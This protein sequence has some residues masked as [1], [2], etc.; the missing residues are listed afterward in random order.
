MYGLK[1]VPFTPHNTGRC[2]CTERVLQAGSWKESAGLRHEAAKKLKEF[3]GGF[4]SA[5]GAL[6]LLD[7]DGTLAPFRVDRFKA[8]PWVGVR[9]LLN[10]IQ[11][12]TK[13]RIAV[14][15]GRPAGEIAPLLELETPPEV[16]GL[17]GVER[18]YPDG[19]REIET[20]APE[21][22]A[23][24]DELKAQLRRNAFGGLLEEKPNAAVMHWRGVAAA[25]AREIERRTRKL[26]EPAAQMQG[27]GLL[28]FEAGVEL[29]AGRDK[30]GAVK[31]ILA[32]TDVE[33]ARKIPAA[34]LG[35]DL[36]DE[37]AFAA[38]KERGLS[39]L[40]R[41]EWRETEAD[42]WLRPPGELKGF[43]REWIAAAAGK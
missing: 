8:R 9:E 28:R 17:H 40:V 5:A 6:L 38:L 35:D 10:Q 31:A 32:E 12:Q 27:L 37:L 20:I 43:L 18:L 1:P 7:Y 33:G 41:R 11:N 22:E 14:I 3:F 29:R 21:V 39:V 30:G 25:K 2:L 19:R 34:F 4:T 15:T 26:F 23:K 16:W 24:L 13:T 42:V 36:T